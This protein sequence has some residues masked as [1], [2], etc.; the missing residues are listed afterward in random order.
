MKEDIY[1]SQFRLPMSLYE[2][3]KKATEENGRSLNAELVSRLEQSFEAGDDD[4]LVNSLRRLHKESQQKVEELLRKGVHPDDN[5]VQL[6]KEA[7]QHAWHL[8]IHVIGRQSR[9]DR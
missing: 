4:A 2:N 1:R 8:L 9:E 5:D 6:Y 3:L 7:T